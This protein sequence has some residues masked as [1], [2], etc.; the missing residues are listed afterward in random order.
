MS[1]IAPPLTSIALLA[2][3]TANCAQVE[4]GAHVSD[5]SNDPLRKKTS[6]QPLE[7]DRSATQIPAEIDP[8]PAEVDPK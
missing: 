1:R 3:L 5:V 7:P 4:P 6:S 2:L 8:P